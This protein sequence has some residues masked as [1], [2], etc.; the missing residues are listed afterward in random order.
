ML[1]EGESFGEVALVEVVSA[2]LKPFDDATGRIKLEGKRLNC[3]LK[4]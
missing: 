4:R 1:S 3:R 2:I